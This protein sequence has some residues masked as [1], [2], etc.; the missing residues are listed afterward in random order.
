V[1]R[2]DMDEN[3]DVT[4]V[5]FS[6]NGK[7]A[8]TGTAYNKRIILWDVS[9]GREI[10]RFSYQ[11]YQYLLP[12][13]DLVFGPDDRTILAP[14]PDGL[15]LWDIKTGMV[16][17]RFY[18]HKAYVWSVDISPDGKYVLSGSD[19]GEVFLWDFSTA[20]LRY[21]LPVHT[22]PVMGLQFS[23]DGKFVYSVS[24]D[25]LLSKWKIPTLQTLPELLEWIHAYR[26]V[27]A[28]SCEEKQHY[29]V[30]PLCEQA[31]P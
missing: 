16:I 24:T 20:E 10:R 11:N 3:E 21:S 31:S 22:Q 14:G 27:R 13:F 28:L 12:I 1:R 5:A 2:F 18:G 17:R 25:G 30:K 7:W 4:G 15:Y 26:Y 6:S 9:T 23:P 8:A 19:S 29:Q